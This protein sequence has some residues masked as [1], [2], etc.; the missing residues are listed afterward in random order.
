[1]PCN[2]KENSM[3]RMAD[4]ALDETSDIDHQSRNKRIKEMTIISD[5]NSVS[6]YNSND[7]LNSG[8][9]N[10]AISKS[11]PQF[12]QKLYDM[13]ETSSND[14]VHSKILCWNS[15][16][17]TSF[18]IYDVKKFEESIFKKFFR[19][20]YSSFK[21]QLCYY[22]FKKV[23]DGPL[24][25]HLPKVKGMLVFRQEDG[26]FCR[27][28]PE[29]LSEVKRTSRAAGATL[30]N[31]NHSYREEA[32][33]L[34]KKVKELENVVFGLKEEILSF[35]KFKNEFVVMKAELNQ[36]KLRKDFLANNVKVEQKRLTSETNFTRRVSDY[37]DYPTGFSSFAL[38]RELSNN[39]SNNSFSLNDVVQFLPKPRPMVNRDFS[40][41]SMNS[42]HWSLLKD[43][44]T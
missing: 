24:M 35:Q 19:S 14:P 23:V 36:L 40:A 31:N 12:L 38:K 7:V 37:P 16:D 4:A 28:R 21:R 22:G 30:T 44:L 43:V 20:A 39:M 27:Y 8:N 26:Y 1:M 5:N 13:V 6:S 2:T 25:S 11:I 41:D 42:Y 29:L 9:T 32:I 18:M 10:S 34:R 33:E 3:K 17:L 15:V